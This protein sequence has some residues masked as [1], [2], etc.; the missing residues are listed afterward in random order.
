MLNEE[1]KQLFARSSVFAG[2][3]TLE[4]GRAVT[5]GDLDTLESLVDKSL[6]RH[7]DDRFWMLATIREFAQERLE[8]SG[9]RLDLQRLHADTSPTSPGTLKRS[10][11]GRRRRAGCRSWNRSS[12]MFAGRSRRRSRTASSSSRLR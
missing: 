3:C 9:E 11:V 10:S 7:S 1:E 8:E 5:G 12:T 6:I 4:A 2:G